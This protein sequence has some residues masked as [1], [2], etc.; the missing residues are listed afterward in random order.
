MAL[1]DITTA[2]LSAPLRSPHSGAL[3]PSAF[4]DAAPSV[5]RMEQS[6]DRILH[7]CER[8]SVPLLAAST[9][10]LTTEDGT[11]AAAAA[12]AAGIC[13]VRM[14]R[15]H[16]DRLIAPMAAAIGQSVQSDGRSR[17]CTSEALTDDNDAFIAVGCGAAHP[18]ADATA[19]AAQ[20]IRSRAGAPMH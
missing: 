2:L 15:A 10:K 17:P 16:A 8:E 18:S 14:R 13:A 19:S 9:S 5:W 3:R 4:P 1:T 7:S 12:A 20:A 11:T 6:I